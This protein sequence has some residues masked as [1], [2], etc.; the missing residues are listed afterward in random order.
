MRCPLFTVIYAGYSAVT[1]MRTADKITEGPDDVFKGNIL[2]SAFGMPLLCDFGLAVVVEDLTR[3]SVSTILQGSGNCRW[4]SSEVL[5]L[6]ELPTKQSDVWAFGMVILEV[7]TF[8][9]RFSGH[10]TYLTRLMSSYS[11]G[12]CPFKDWPSTH[13]SCSRWTKAGDPTS[14]QAKLS[15]LGLMTTYGTSSSLVGPNGRKVDRPRQ[16]SSPCLLL[17]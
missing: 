2:V 12:R 11:R 1:K 3:T 10:S 15:S 9:F 8:P 16:S 4:M 17:S 6:G 7:S 5:L 13:R 14:R